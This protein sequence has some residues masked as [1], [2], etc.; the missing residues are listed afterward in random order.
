MKASLLRMLAL[1]PLDLLCNC[2]VFGEMEVQGLR[3]W[4]FVWIVIGLAPELRLRQNHLLL[5]GDIVF[6]WVVS[7][8]FWNLLVFALRLRASHCHC[9]RYFKLC[10]HEIW[11]RTEMIVCK[12]ICLD[13]TFKC[14]LPIHFQHSS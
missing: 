12:V 3:L 1:D 5:A 6:V 13:R 4:S 2:V 8:F 11:R 9:S 14:H 10:G 7:F